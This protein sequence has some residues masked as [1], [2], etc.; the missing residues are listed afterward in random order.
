MYTFHA[1]LFCLYI[2]N[3]PIYNLCIFVICIACVNTCMYIYRPEWHHVIGLPFSRATNLE[4]T[5]ALSSG[6][7][8]VETW[9]A[10]RKGR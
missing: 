4:N 8:P 1:R 10:A 2:G 7:Q 3:L 5:G 6:T 9:L